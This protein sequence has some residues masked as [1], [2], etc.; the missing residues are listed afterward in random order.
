[1]EHFRKIV[2]YFVVKF[3]L[4]SSIEVKY[5]FKKIGEK[6]QNSEKKLRKIEK[7]FRKIYIT[8]GESCRKSVE[9]PNKFRERL[10]VKH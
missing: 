9:F 6:L 5:A 1:M 8:L 3:E 2:N 10:K 4:I 7:T